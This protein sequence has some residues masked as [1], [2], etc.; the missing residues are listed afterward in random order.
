M[1]RNH[2]NAFYLIV[3]QRLMLLDTLSCDLTDGVLNING[4]CVF[5]WDLISFCPCI[6]KSLPHDPGRCAAGNRLCMGVGWML[7]LQFLQLWRVVAEPVIRNAT[8]SN[9]L[10]SLT[11]ICLGQVLIKADEVIFPFS[12]QTTGEEK[13]QGEGEKLHFIFFPLLR[14][15]LFLPLWENEQFT[16]KMSRVW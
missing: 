11:L 3:F 4:R 2:S 15:D 13:N 5:F 14:G 6:L 8:E 12:S 10:S 7:M 9:I 16:Q 1:R